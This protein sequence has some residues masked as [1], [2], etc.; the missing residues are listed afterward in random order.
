MGQDGAAYGASTGRG[1]RGLEYK[2]QPAHRS[3][4]SLWALAPQERTREQ[5]RHLHGREAS[6][7]NGANEDSLQ[8]SDPTSDT[9]VTT[10]GSLRPPGP[11]SPILQPHGIVVKTQGD[12]TQSKPLADVVHHLYGGAKGRLNGNEPA[13]GRDWS[14]HSP[15]AWERGLKGT[16]HTAHP[17]SSGVHEV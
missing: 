2:H 1:V 11:R 3:C 8:G 4:Q 9:P 17:K 14:S 10:D 6:H 12:Q 15:P 7:G 16:I 13:G 5:G